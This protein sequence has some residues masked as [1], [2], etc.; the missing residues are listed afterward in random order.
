HVLGIKFAANTEPAADVAFEEMHT[1]RTAPEHAGDTVA[2]PVWHFG[3]AVELQHVAG[4]VVIGDGAA[5]LERNAGMASDRGVQFHHDGRVAKR[6]RDVA[7]G[8]FDARR[9]RRTSGLE[10]PR[11]CAR[12]EYGG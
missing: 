8:F 5:R 12:V 2:V 3:G 7:V 11:R 10:F 6:G 4:A 1:R 9:L